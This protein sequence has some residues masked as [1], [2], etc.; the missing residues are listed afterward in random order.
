MMHNVKTIENVQAQQTIPAVNQ[1]L[2]LDR[3]INTA[4]QAL[5]DKVGQQN[6]VHQQSNYFNEDEPKHNYDNSVQARS[7][8]Y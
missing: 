3:E 7:N 6:N 4:M 5:R 2:T 1:Q 8:Y